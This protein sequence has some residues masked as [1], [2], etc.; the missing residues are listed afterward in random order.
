MLTFSL[1]IYTHTHS[2]RRTHVALNLKS[3]SLGLRFMIGLSHMTDVCCQLVSATGTEETFL[4]LGIHLVL[5]G[6]RH[7]E[8][9]EIAVLN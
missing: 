5:T 2:S 6:H 9:P 7:F 1:Y 3:S 8:F 4:H